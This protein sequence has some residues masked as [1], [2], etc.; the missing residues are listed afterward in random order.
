MTTTMYRVQAIENIG[1]DTEWLMPTEDWVNGKKLNE[2]RSSKDVTKIKVTD[3]KE[4]FIQDIGENPDYNGSRKLRCGNL[5]GYS[6]PNGNIVFET[7]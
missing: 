1:I 4:F 5:N 3:K 7:N 6:F 2:L